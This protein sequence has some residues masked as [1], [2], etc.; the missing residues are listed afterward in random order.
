MVVENRENVTDMCLD[1]I[2]CP[3]NGVFL[4]RQVLDVESIP[5]IM[6]TPCLDFRAGDITIV[7]LLL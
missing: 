7:Q 5:F 3:F 1:T 4:S 6:F 2:I